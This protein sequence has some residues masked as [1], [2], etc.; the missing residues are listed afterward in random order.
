MSVAHD[1]DTREL[2]GARDLYIAEIY[3]VAPDAKTEKP[4]GRIFYTN[5]PPEGRTGRLR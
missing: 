4:Y 3:E 2:M 1:S 5:V